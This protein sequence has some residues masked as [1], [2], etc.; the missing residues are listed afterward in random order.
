MGSYAAPALPP[1]DAMSVS[2]HEKGKSGW[3]LV[4]FICRTNRN[5]ER[6]FNF[7][8]FT[9]KIRKIGRN[10]RLKKLQ[11]YFCRNLQYCTVVVV[12]LFGIIDPTSD[13]NSESIKI[14]LMSRQTGRLVRSP[15]LQ[16][17]EGRK[18]PTTPRKSERRPRKVANLQGTLARN[19][20]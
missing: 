10:S 2:W 7:G 8:F 11:K 20:A 17:C 1:A 4:T 12:V 18:S 19:T 6:N 5:P 3:K 14:L 15:S 9:Q 13:Q 16:L